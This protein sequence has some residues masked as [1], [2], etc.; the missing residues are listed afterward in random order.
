MRWPIFCCILI[1][2]LPRCGC[3]SKKK[4]DNSIYDRPHADGDVD[5]QTSIMPDKRKSLP[6][7]PFDLP[8]LGHLPKTP[9]QPYPLLNGRPTIPPLL[10]GNRFSSYEPRA[11]SNSR[12]VLMNG[13]INKGYYEDEYFYRTGYMTERNGCS[14]RDIFPGVYNYVENLHGNSFV[15]NKQG[16]HHPDEG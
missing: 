7:T 6:R 11:D 14:P 10:S 16:R 13:Q 5:V 15:A 1:S 3:A 9:L 4:E 8:S 12:R 2:I